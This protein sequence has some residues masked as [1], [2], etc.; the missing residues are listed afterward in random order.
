[1]CCQWLESII[2]PA[3]AKL[4][5]SENVALFKIQPDAAAAPSTSSQTAASGARSRL[6]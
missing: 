3:C 1:V 5:A 4:S 2:D 6:S